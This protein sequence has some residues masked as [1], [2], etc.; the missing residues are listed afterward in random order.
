MTSACN[1]GEW[2][3]GPGADRK[4][5][6]VAWVCDGENDCGDWSDEVS[7]ESVGG[8]CMISNK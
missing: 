3:C 5:I 6:S 8:K 2:Q 4:C 1:S 7:D